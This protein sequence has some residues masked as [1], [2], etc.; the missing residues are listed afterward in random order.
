M[1]LKRVGRSFVSRLDPKRKRRQRTKSPHWQRRK[2][3]HSE[4]AS[5]TFSRQIPT[6]I[7]VELHC[8]KTSWSTRPDPRR[9]RRPPTQRRAS[10]PTTSITPTPTSGMSSKCARTWVPTW[11]TCGSIAVWWIHTLT[12]WRALPLLPHTH[13]IRT[14]AIQTYTPTI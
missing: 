14:E 4:D 7:W 3:I 8:S 13:N 9:R 12:V 10:K 6:L 5:E 11:L 1:S 2:Y